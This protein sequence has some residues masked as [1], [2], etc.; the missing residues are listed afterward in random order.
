MLHRDSFVSHEIRI[1]S[2]SPI[3]TPLKTFP[4]PASEK[5]MVLDTWWCSF[6]NFRVVFS[7]APAVHGF[8]GVSH[9]I[10]GWTNG[11]SRFE[12][13]KNPPGSRWFHSRCHHWGRKPVTWQPFFFG[14]DL[15]RLL[16]PIFLGNWKPLKPATIVL[17][18]GHQRLSREEN[19][20]ENGR[21]PF[22]SSSFEFLVG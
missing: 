20:D 19:L 9:A 10:S 7:G 15:E 8:Q 12:N 18:I 21:N 2:F 17:K 5:R 22:F 3:S 4:G 6:S 14:G 1:L 11:F 13:P 16:C